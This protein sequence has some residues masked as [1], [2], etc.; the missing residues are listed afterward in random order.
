[1]FATLTAPSFGP[2]HARRERGGK[3]LPCRPRR[4][5][6]KRVCPHG[7]D[8]SCAA[9]H[10]KDDPR[11]GRAMCGDCYDYRAAVLFNAA[12]GELW[13]RFTTYL[14][15]HLARLGGISQK[16]FRE[17]VKVRFVKVAEYQA[18]GVVHFHALI[19]LDA[20]TG[21]CAPPDPEW[22]TERLE[23]AVKAAAVQASVPLS[24]RPAAPC[25]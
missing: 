8:I 17:L 4:D 23:T 20:S 24:A 2:V 19:R 9:R 15:R 3:V 25:C 14:P 10:A 11:L 12:A 16:Q 7:R 13:R 22:T 6:S 1:V 18:R 21:T 5:A